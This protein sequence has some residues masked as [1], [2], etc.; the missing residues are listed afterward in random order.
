MY[1]GKEELCQNSNCTSWLNGYR[2]KEREAR[3]AQHFFLY[4]TRKNSKW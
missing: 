2:V 4:E 3:E 1:T